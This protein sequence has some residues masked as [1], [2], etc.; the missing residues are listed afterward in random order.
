MPLQIYY[1]H[2]PVKMFVKESSKRLTILWYIDFDFC[3]C[4]II[5][6]HLKPDQLNLKFCKQT[7]VISMLDNK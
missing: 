2:L 4:K 5:T 3:S 7:I 6:I 1:E